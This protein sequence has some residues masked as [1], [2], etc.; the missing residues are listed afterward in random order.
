MMGGG[1]VA[2]IVPTSGM[3]ARIRPNTVAGAG[4]A[5][6][7]VRDPFFFIVLPHVSDIL[8]IPGVCQRQP[9]LNPY[10]N[11][12]P[13]PIMI[14]TDKTPAPPSSPPTHRRSRACR[15]A[16]LR[17]LTGLSGVSSGRYYDH[18]ARFLNIT[19]R[20]AVIAAVVCHLSQYNNRARGKSS[21]LKIFFGGAL[22]AEP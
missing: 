3:A 7:E 4:C 16:Y 21:F 12:Y 18:L 13:N 2:N 10:L 17:R 5:V 22:A 8:D 1:G 6:C 20:T 9:L 14:K 19:S 11:P 15:T